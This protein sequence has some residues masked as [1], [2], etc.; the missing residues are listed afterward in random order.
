M[1]EDESGTNSEDRDLSL[2]SKEISE[3]GAWVRHSEKIQWAFV[4]VFF[5]ITLILL[6][7]LFPSDNGLISKNPIE[8]IFLAASIPIFWGC[9]CY[10][11]KEVANLAGDILSLLD[12]M[13]VDTHLSS[14]IGADFGSPFKAPI[15]VVIS[16]SFILFTISSLYAIFISLCK[17]L[18]LP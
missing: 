2:R 11:Y 10:A 5:G 12:K 17:Y 8:S 7:V 9:I 3:I 6:G 18:D 1:K 13:K 15:G 16:A 14:K 4:S